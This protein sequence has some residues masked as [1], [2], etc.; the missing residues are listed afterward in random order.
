MALDRRFGFVGAAAMTMLVQVQV[1][2][3]DRRFGF[4][5]AD[6]GAGDAGA[7]TPGSASAFWFARAAA[8]LVQVQVLALDPGLVQALALDRRFVLRVQPCCCWCFRFVG[9]AAALVLAQDR[10]FVLRV[11]LVLLL[12]LDRRF[13]WPVLVPC[14]C[15]RWLWISVSFCVMPGM[16]SRRA[17]DGIQNGIMSCQG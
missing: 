8:M 7:G 11:L 13:V 1:P 9:A 4:A 3:L 5:G 15:R 16:T 10:C 17:R 2:A 6:A 12:A 14:W